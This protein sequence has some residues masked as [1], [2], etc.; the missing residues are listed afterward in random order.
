M[1]KS[2]ISITTSSAILSDPDAPRDKL[3]RSAGRRPAGS[4]SSWPR[5]LF[6]IGLFAAV[7]AGAYYAYHHYYARRHGYGRPA[8]AMMMGRG[9]RGGFGDLYSNGKRF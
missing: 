7:C 3:E 8:F 1:P 2:I 4:P 5:F 9:S 6:K